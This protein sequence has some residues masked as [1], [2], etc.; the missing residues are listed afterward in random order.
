MKL[1]LARSLINSDVESFK[2]YGLLIRSSEKNSEVEEGQ[3]AQIIERRKKYWKNNNIWLNNDVKFAGFSLIWLES[4]IP[5]EAELH[6]YKYEYLE[7]N[8]RTVVLALCLK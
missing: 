8:Y 4:L 6:F 5:T 1:S 2:S 3:E 7:E